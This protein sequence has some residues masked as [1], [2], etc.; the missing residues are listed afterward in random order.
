M[1]DTDSEDV[2]VPGI[3]SLFFSLTINLFTFFLSVHLFTS[4]RAKASPTFHRLYLPHLAAEDDKETKSEEHESLLKLYGDGMESV[5]LLP[6][7]KQDKMLEHVGLDGYIYLQTYE[8]G[9]KL[10]GILSI[11]MLPL[12]LIYWLPPEC[13]EAHGLNRLSISNVPDSSSL[14]FFSVLASYGVTVLLFVLLAIASRDFR[15]LRFKLLNLKPPGVE[16]FML[17]VRDIPSVE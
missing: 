5:R 8:I 16:D 1:G 14:M 4:W 2:E 12:A 17:L 9:Q 13:E 11:A 10:F 6:G 7:T 3:D 15:K